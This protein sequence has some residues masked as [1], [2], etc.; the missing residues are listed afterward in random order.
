MYGDSWGSEIQY[1]FLLAEKHQFITGID[2]QRNYRQDL[3]NFDIYGVYLD[4]KRDSYQWGAYIQDEYQLNDKWVINLGLRHDESDTTDSS[5]NP[6]LGL[7]YQLDSTQ[8][9]KFLYGTA[10]RA[11]NAYELYYSDGGATFVQTDGLAPEEIES[12]ELVYETMSNPGLHWVASVYQNKIENL[13][14]LVEYPLD[15]SLVWFQNEGQAKTRGAD[16][17]LIKK[18]ENKLEL[19][20]SLSIQKTE[21]MAGAGTC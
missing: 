9:M 1:S 2:Y 5:L 14:A 21:D 20:A 16:V 7:I 15:T 6:R 4:E 17:E 19:T 11:P 10:F 18:F 8:T 13:I 3:T 12:F